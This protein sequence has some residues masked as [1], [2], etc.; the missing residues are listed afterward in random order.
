MTHDRVDPLRDRARVPHAFLLLAVSLAVGSGCSQPVS[1]QPDADALSRGRSSGLRTIPV[2]TI[3]PDRADLRKTTTQPAHVEPFEQAD[4]FAKTSGY[5]QSIAVDIGDRVT[6]GQVLAELFIPEMETERAHK[7]AQV[8]QAEAER[9]QAEASLLVAESSIDAAEAR[10]EESRAG[11][12]RARAEVALWT[13]EFQRTEMLVGRDAATRSLLDETR[14][15]RLSAEAGVLMANAQVKSAEASLSEARAELAKAKADVEAA[16][17]RVE[18]ARAELEHSLVLMSYAKIEAP[19]DGLIIRRR[20]DP[21]AFIRSAVE[22]Q[23]VP[24]VSLA[25]VDRKRIVVEIPESEAGWVE[26]GQPATFRSNGL[27]MDGR[28][29]RIA[30]ALAPGTRT[31]RT[32]IRL[33]RPEEIRPGTYGQI[34]IVLAD[35]PDAMVLPSVAVL[36]DGDRPAVM[37]AEDGKALR[38]EVEVGL[39]NGEQAQILGGI[40]GDTRVIL[41]GNNAVRD[42]QPIEIVG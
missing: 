33:E 30:D 16:A 37:V 17:R 6:E 34:T 42:G 5:L 10:L 26:I 12:D 11:I 8:S 14:S 22:N 27:S 7:H 2:R 20:A 13:S 25:R 32:E 3:R 15:K 36:H 28:V 40:D 31:M 19:F 21:G 23:P 24:I 18:V 38:V 4:L 29:A 9:R 35:Y 39:D 41:D 1:G